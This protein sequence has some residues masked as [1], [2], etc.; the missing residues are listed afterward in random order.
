MN[1]AI[2][3][4]ESL[5]TETLIFDYP[6]NSYEAENMEN[7]QLLKKTASG[8]QEFTD[9]LGISFCRVMKFECTVGLVLQVYI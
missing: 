8:R 3:L 2:I 1:K 5:T 4:T 7:S 6:T 9:Y